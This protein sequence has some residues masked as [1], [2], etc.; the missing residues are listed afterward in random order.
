MD[1]G[2]SKRPKIYYHARTVYQPKK[3]ANISVGEEVFG[4]GMQ[5]WGE[6]QR[7]EPTKHEKAVG[8]V[9]S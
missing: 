5:M 1:D 3:K 8:Y 2:G 4:V 7:Y 6:A 9:A